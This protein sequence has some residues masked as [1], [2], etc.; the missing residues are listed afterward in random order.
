MPQDL[1]R[2]IAFADRITG[3]MWIAASEPKCLYANRPLLDYLGYSLDEIQQDGWRK[4]VHPEEITDYLQMV[5]QK[6]AQC[7]SFYRR[8]RLRKADGNYGRV[9]LLAWPHT[10]KGVYEAFVGFLAE[11]QEPVHTDVSF[12]RPAPN[13]KY[14]RQQE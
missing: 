14:S 3:M 10:A 11:E 2:L 1:K 7:E 12:A 13:R 8:L 9:L 6:F 5:T 4:T